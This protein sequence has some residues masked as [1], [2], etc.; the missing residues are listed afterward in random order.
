M[1]RS[2]GPGE[3][4][5]NRR[6]VAIVDVGRESTSAVYTHFD[7]A[8]ARYRLGTYAILKQIE[9]ARDSG[10][11]FV[12]LGMYVASNRHLNYK[13]RFMPQQRLCHGRWTD[14][15]RAPENLARL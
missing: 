6:P 1:I 12:Y 14:F 3:R 11:R 13:A 10:R 15:D 7:P 2:P 4:L 9:W 5:A 8:A